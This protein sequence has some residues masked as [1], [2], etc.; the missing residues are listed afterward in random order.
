[1]NA[2]YADVVSLAEAKESI[3]GLPTGVFRTSRLAKA[4]A[5]ELIG[6]GR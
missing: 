5:P 2:K 3:A 4:P 1:M 6:S